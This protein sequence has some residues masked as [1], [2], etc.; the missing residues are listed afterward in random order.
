[1]ILFWVTLSSAMTIPEELSPQLASNICG[2]LI[3]DFLSQY[4]LIISLTIK[5]PI[6][7]KCYT[8]LRTCS[9]SMVLLRITT[10]WT[11]TEEDEN[12]RLLRTSTP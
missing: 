6:R 2:C 10:L 7:M 8:V 1:M 4:N 9:Q 5:Q 11:R 12:G 3:P